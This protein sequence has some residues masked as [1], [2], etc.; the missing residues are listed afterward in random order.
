MASAAERRTV[1]LGWTE[2]YDYQGRASERLF[3]FRVDSITVTRNSWTVRT[4]ITNTSAL[5][6][7]M[8]IR[9]QFAIVAGSRV[10]RASR[11]SPRLPAELAIGARWRG[12]FGGAGALPPNVL[13]RIR[14]GVFRPTILPGAPGITWVTRHSIRL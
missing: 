8:R 9:N 3:V 5:R 1:P 14:F 2:N 7:S 11:F 12:M 10:F 13:L 4:S 6:M